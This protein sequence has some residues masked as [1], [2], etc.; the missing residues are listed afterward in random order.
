MFRMLILQSLYNLSDEQVEYQVRDR[1][2]T[3]SL[4]RASRQVCA[5][6]SS[7]Y[8]HGVGGLRE[9]RSLATVASRPPTVS[10]YASTADLTRPR[11]HLQAVIANSPEVPRPHPPTTER[12]HAQP[13]LATR[14]QEPRE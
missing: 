4:Q 1:L 13:H 5:R 14:R 2:R 3:G 11:F 6:R 9:E 12:N 8:Y 7:E 10:R